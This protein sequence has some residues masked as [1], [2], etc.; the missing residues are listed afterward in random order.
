MN[1]ETRKGWPLLTVETEAKGDSRSTYERVPSL[2]GSLHGH[3]VLLQEIFVFLHWLF[4]SVQC[5]IY[6]SPPYTISLHFSRR[7]ASWAGSRA[8]SPVS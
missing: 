5:R 7:P 2:V 6:F 4:F 3:I 8:A 1:K